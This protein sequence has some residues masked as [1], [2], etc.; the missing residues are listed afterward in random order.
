MR[1]M[2]SQTV[3]IGALIFVAALMYSCVG[4]AG[5]SGYLAVMTLA[6]IAPAVIKPTALSFNIAVA[7]IATVQFARAGAFSWKLFW[8][9]AISS[10]PLAFLGGHIRLSDAVFKPILAVALVVAALRLVVS[11]PARPIKPLPTGVAIVC[12]GVIGLVSGMV[13]VGGGIF[14]SP[15]ILLAG[16]SDVRTTAGVSA[17]FILINSVAGLLG[18]LRSTGT[19]PAMAPIWAVAAVAGGVLGSYM[20]SRRLSLESLR[21][22]LA[23]VLVVA[24]AKLCLG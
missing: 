8:P 3:W 6:G 21:R 19:F 23:A 20:G 11:W 5:A 17:A 14:L 18:D 12:G 10:V 13:G 9:F 24:A 22:V 1:A 2:D 16:W 4:H 7:L 15:L